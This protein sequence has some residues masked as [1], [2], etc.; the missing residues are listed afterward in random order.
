[1]YPFIENEIFKEEISIYEMNNFL[2]VSSFKYINN[3]RL[4]VKLSNWIYEELKIMKYNDSKLLK[5]LYFMHDDITQSIINFVSNKNILDK[6]FSDRLSD[7]TP[8]PR[9]ITTNIVKLFIEMNINIHMK[10]DL[11]FQRSCF[12]NCI[13]IVVILLDNGSKINDQLILKCADRKKWN[14]ETLKLLLMKGNYNK[15]KISDMARKKI[16]KLRLYYLI[17]YV[18]RSY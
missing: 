14:N 17:G 4:I 18:R 9:L 2:I 11:F 7:K 1:M 6:Y 3:Y 12:L 5:S 16:I 10:D 13:D 15:E 8:F